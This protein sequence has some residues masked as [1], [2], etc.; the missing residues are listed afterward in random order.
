MGAPTGGGPNPVGGGGC[1]PNPGGGANPWGG[2]PNPTCDGG[3]R[4]G[5]PGGG[6]ARDGWLNPCGGGGGRCCVGCWDGIPWYAPP[7]IMGGTPLPAPKSAGGTGAIPR[8]VKSPSTTG[9]G[10]ID[11]VGAAMT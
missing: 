1:R 2:P 10:G 3:G 4:A 5:S 11:G 7:F 9:V 6:V 8:A